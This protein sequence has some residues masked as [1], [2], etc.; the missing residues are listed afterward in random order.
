MILLISSEKTGFE[1]NLERHLYHIRYSE[2]YIDL[3][4]NYINIKLDKHIQ[5]Y[6]IN[7]KYV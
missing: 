3:I 5:K 1:H 6:H 7:K 4:L 2:N